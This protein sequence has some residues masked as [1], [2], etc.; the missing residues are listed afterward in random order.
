M[1]GAWWTGLV[2]GASLA[3]ILLLAIFFSPTLL[4]GWAIDV[5]LPWFA[6]A[7]AWRPAGTG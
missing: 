5:A 4:L 1:P 2:I 7:A 3:S 6:L